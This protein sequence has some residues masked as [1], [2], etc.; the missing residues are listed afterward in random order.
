MH[1]VNW[2]AKRGFAADVFIVSGAMVKPFIAV[3][4]IRKALLLYLDALKLF[5]P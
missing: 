3:C 4:I 2:L 5:I 1:M